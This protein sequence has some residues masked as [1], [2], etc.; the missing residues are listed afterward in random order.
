VEVT[1]A[2]GY[3]AARQRL[4]LVQAT[5][6]AVLPYKEHPGFPGSGAVTDYLARGVPVVATDV[7]N[8][9][10][11][12]GEAGV[13]VPPGDPAALASALDRVAGDRDFLAGLQT[14]A[15]RRAALFSPATHA[16]RSLALFRQVAQGLR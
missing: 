7:A 15:R 12:V 1:V 6:L 5:D 2:P 3:L 14:A 13:I 9:R 10:E 8:M 16:M 11:L 4:A